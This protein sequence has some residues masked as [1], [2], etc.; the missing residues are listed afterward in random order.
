MSLDTQV[1]DQARMSLTS[2]ADALAMARRFLALF[3]QNSGLAEDRC[4]EVVQAAA[5]LM[6][7]GGRLRGALALRVQE[8]HD[9]LTV[10]IDLVGPDPVQVSDEAAAL[11]NEL[12]P[13]WG[14]R[15]LPGCTQAWCEF[16]THQPKP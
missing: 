16:P 11:L 9:H 15:Q 12:S 3:P 1:L 6:T 13:E 8:H 10:L 14:W 7:V 5:E 2:D 4:D